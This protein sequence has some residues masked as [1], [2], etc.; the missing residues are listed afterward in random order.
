MNNI[1]KFLETECKRIYNAHPKYTLYEKYKYK[2]YDELYNCLYKHLDLKFITD[3]RLDLYES[4]I[5]IH[6][7]RAI[8]YMG[9]NGNLTVDISKID[10]INYQ[11]LVQKGV[12]TIKL[13]ANV[14]ISGATHI[15]HL[16]HS[17]NYVYIGD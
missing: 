4:N 8:V 17:D 14:E 15:F 1:F 13:N 2:I 12:F 7:D 5:K 3:F 16:L 6:S 11:D 9:N 10:S